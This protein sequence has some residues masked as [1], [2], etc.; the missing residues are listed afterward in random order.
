VGVCL[1]RGQRS[2]T[3][4]STA[5]WS[6]SAARRTGRCTLQPSRW[7]N[8]A[9]TC[10]GW[11]RTSVSRSITSVMRSRVHSSPVNRLAVAPFSRTCSTWPSWRSDSRGVGPVGP[12]L[13]RASGPPACQRASQSLTLSRETPA[14]G[15]PRPGR[16]RRRTAQQRGAGEPGGVHAPV[17]PQHGGKWLA[18]ADP[19]RPSHQLQ[20]DRP[21]C[22]VNPQGPVGENGGR[23][24]RGNPR[25]LRSVWPGHVL[26]PGG[27]TRDR[28]SDGRPSPP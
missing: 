20:L 7:C 3:Q 27:G 8:S 11:W 26:R 23:G 21:S 9:H 25:D 22:Q 13:R 15:R 17:V 19:A 24:R 5:T 6:R 14:G 12:W 18:C 2:L 16:G 28:Q 4:R 1:I 10:A